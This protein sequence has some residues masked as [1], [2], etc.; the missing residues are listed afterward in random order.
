[1]FV[2]GLT[3]GIGTGKT[4]VSEILSE[5]GATIINAD[6]VGHDAYLPGTKTFQD[7]VD[8]F[9]DDVVSESGEIDRRKLGPIVFGDPAKMDQLNAIMHPRIYE[10]IEERIA[11]LN[12]DGVT[13]IVIEAAILIE[14][15]WTP[16]A[17]E[18]WVTT[19]PEEAVIARL[20]DRNNMDEETA[21]SRIS[22]QMSQE[23]RAGHAHAVI[24]NDRGLDELREH[25]EETWRQRALSQ[26]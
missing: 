21:R 8:A 22:S 9:G 26:T 15:G 18:I 4:Q 16:L 12:G 6:L 7:V 11:V 17:D 20:R 5:L 1:M 2:I 25:V 3:G 10:M 19:S 14:A 24:A 13:R 23:E